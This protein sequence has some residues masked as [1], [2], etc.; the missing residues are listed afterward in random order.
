MLFRI[1][2]YEIGLGHCQIPQSTANA[3]QIKRVKFEL[4]VGRMDID[5]KGMGFE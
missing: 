5:G 2:L 3:D 4:Y 1:N